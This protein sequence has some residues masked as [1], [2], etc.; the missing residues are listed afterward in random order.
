[1][2]RQAQKESAR[3]EAENGMSD[4]LTQQN[5]ILLL[6]ESYGNGWCRLPVIL[7]LRIA[8][9]RAR[10]SELRQQGHDIQCKT[11]WVGGIRHSLY[12]IV[13]PARREA[14]QLELIG[15]AS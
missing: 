2:E 4:R 6:L 12:R 13:P 8:N 3:K 9:Y 11:E 5:R 15:R 1:V 10:I 14:E 7:D